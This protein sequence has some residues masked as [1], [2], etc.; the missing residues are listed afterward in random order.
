MFVFGFVLV[1]ALALVFVLVLVLSYPRLPKDQRPSPHP[2]PFTPLWPT[3]SMAH[4]RGTAR[5][6]AR[7]TQGGNQGKRA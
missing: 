2:T 3:T 4:K 6:Q 7:E 5:E 1:L